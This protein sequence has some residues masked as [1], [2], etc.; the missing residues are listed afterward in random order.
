VP[1]PTAEALGDFRKALAS[2]P[3]HPAGK[4]RFGR[5]FFRPEESGSDSENHFLHSKNE[6]LRRKNHFLSQEFHFFTE[7]NEICSEEFH[8][9]SEENEIFSEEFDF[10]RQE[11]HFL[12]EEIQFL[13]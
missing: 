9:L 2:F 7:E 11:N 3:G 10:C 4:P 13:R 5:G 6:I 12:W 1:S 8:F